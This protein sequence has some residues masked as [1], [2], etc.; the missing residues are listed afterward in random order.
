MFDLTSLLASPDAPL[1]PAC[2]R[3]RS[4]GRDLFALLQVG[5]DADARA[6]SP[7]T[8][9]PA[10]PAAAPH[11]LCSAPKR[12]VTLSLPARVRPLPVIV[13]P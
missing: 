4:P 7:R 12:E 2:T 3:G 9:D 11:H 8:R 13:E 5:C 6:A 1:A 10:P